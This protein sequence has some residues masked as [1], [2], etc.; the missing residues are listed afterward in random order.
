M[1][2]ERSSNLLSREPLTKQLLFDHITLEV[3]V[4]KEPF[5]DCKWPSSRAVPARGSLQQASW[6]RNRN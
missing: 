3:T 4:E 2:S 6:A 1:S 5:L